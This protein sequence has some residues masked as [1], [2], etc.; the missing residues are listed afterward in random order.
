MDRYITGDDLAAFSG[1][2]N[3]SRANIIAMNAAAANGVAR[4]AKSF[5]AGRNNVHEFSVRLKNRGITSQKA[6]G[7]CWMFAALNCL[8]FKVI[9]ELDLDG[10]E[11]SQNYMLF[12]DKLEKANYFLESVY[13]TLGESENSRLLDFLLRSPVQDG[14]QWDMISALIRKYGV[15]P[16]AAMPETACSSDTREACRAITEQL[17]SYAAEIRARYASGTGI[18]E[19]RAGKS[20]MLNTVYRMLCICFGTPPETFDF[21]VRTR[22]GRF[23]ADRGLTP[24]AFF[25]KYIH[26]DL[27]QYISL[28]NAPT[29]DKPYMKSYTVAYLGNVVGERPVRYVNLPI[30]E[31]KKAAIAQLQAGEPVWFGC[32]CGKMADREGG[33]WDAELYGY[34][35]MFAT[36]FDMTKE[37]MLDY[38]LSR[39]NHAMVFQGVDLDEAGRPVRWCV[40]NSWG[41]DRGENGMYLMTDAWFDKFMYQV[42]VSK[43][44]LPREITEA[45]EAEPAVLSPWDPMGALA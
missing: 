8:R 4:T 11:L 26:T 1:E 21:E 3:A 29:A 35:D 37:Q 20:D 28:I 7:R 32:D 22:G 41:P 42:V 45:Y 39:M 19:L 2:F 10:F 40:E 38:G 31:L 12:Y 34:E 16:K 43:K 23:I 9:Q 44:Y 30:E 36:A 5:S 15:V 17:R 6:S 33:V 18:S 24:G 14:G 25:D 27:T 13:A